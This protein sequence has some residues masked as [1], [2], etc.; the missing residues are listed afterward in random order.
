MKMHIVKN[1]AAIPSDQL[2]D[3]GP[4]GLPEGDGPISQLRGR[5]MEATEDERVESGIWEC[6]PGR[7]RR[8]VV[9]AELCHFLSGNCTFEND[10]GE[11]IDIEAGDSIYFPENS[12]GIWDVSETVRKSFVCFD[13]PPAKG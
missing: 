8:Q 1:T 13:M 12:T 6:T 9:Q 4:V 5:I 3:W 11:T 2:D 7:W 10:N